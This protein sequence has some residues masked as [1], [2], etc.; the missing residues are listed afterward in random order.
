[1]DLAPKVRY[2]KY[3]LRVTR[4]AEKVLPLGARSAPRHQFHGAKHGSFCCMNCC[5]AVEKAIGRIC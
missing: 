5:Q 4:T 1:M 3:S 2:T